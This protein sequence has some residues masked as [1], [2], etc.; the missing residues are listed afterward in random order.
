[1][2]C[3]FRF[4]F[5]IYYFVFCLLGKKV[6][7]KME[8]KKKKK[9]KEEKIGDE[10]DF[11]KKKFG[12]KKDKKKMDKKVKVRVGCVFF[13]VFFLRLVVVRCNLVL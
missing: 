5:K 8:D 7:E 11:D 12:N 6:K 3:F 1:M 4:V 9:G 13:Y 10:D 2:F